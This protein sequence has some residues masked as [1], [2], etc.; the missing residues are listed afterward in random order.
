MPPLHSHSRFHSRYSAVPC[1]QIELS[2]T[3]HIASYTI[4]YHTIYYHLSFSRLSRHFSTFVCGFFFL[5]FILKVLLR[6]TK[7]VFVFDIYP[8]Y[9]GR[10][11]QPPVRVAGRRDPTMASACPAAAVHA[12]PNDADVVRHSCADVVPNRRI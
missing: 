2:A 10:T 3:P 6:V 7:I 8:T 5:F 12:A 4:I 9:L 11:Q 1:M